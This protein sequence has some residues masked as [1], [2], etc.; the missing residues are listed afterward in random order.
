MLVWSQH[1]KKEVVELEKVQT[2]K[3]MKRASVQG[4]DIKKAKNVQPGKKLEGEHNHGLQ[5]HQGSTV[6]N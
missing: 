6:I 2:A 3:M 1:F 4:I 5:H